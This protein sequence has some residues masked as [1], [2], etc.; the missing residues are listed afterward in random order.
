MLIAFNPAHGPLLIHRHTCRGPES[1]SVP[2][3]MT[4]AIIVCE[5]QGRECVSYKANV[6]DIY[7][8]IPCGLQLPALVF[9]SANIRLI[10]FKRESYKILLSFCERR[11]E[12]LLQISRFIVTDTAKFYQCVKVCVTYIFLINFM[13]MGPCIFIYEDHINNQREATFYALYC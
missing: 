6:V 1:Q 5:L 4:L 8:L 3:G 13:F 11:K 2:Y 9:L 12:Q 10:F 7:D